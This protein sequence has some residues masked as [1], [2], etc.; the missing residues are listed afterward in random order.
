M[1]RTGEMVL[2]VLGGIF[3]ILGGLFA[4]F[5][6]GLGAALGASGASEVIGLGTAAVILG[7]IGIIGGAIVNRNTRLAGGLMLFSGVAGFIAISLFWVI[8]GILLIVG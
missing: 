8:G 6:G 4:V 1:G 2:G 3:G 5:F 7:I